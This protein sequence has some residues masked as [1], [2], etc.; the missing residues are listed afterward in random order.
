MIKRRKK[1][2]TK[3]KLIISFFCFV[4]RNMSKHKEKRKYF[5]GDGALA[6]LFYFQIA[7]SG[8][9]NSYSY[10]CQ[11]VDYSDNPLA[12]RVSCVHEIILPRSLTLCTCFFVLFF[13]YLHSLFRT[14]PHPYIQ[15]IQ[16][17]S[18]PLSDS[19]NYKLLPDG[20][21]C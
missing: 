17:P 13:S 15:I 3:E 9:A 19:L 6:L 5:F 4:F 7:M 11:P 12:I 1:K 16:M 14:Y 20:F 21:S 8:W 2:G 10:R 18:P